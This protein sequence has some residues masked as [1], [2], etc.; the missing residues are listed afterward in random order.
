MK[1]TTK[2]I[3]AL[4]IACLFALAL[5]ACNGNNQGAANKTPEQLL[6]DALQKNREITS[7]KMG[8]GMDV[9]LSILGQ[10]MDMTIDMDVTYTAKKDMYMRMSTNMLGQDQ[11]VE[12]YL[13][14]QDDNSAMAYMGNNGQWVKQLVD[15]SEM[16]GLLSEQATPSE[17]LDNFV[18][19]KD[20]KLAGEE[21]LNGKPAQKLTGK[22]SAAFLKEALASSGLDD[23][24]GDEDFEDL[25]APV[26]LWISDGYIVRFDMDASDMM[27]QIYTALMQGEGFQGEL[28]VGMTYQITFSDFNTAVVEVPA[29][30]QS[31]PDGD[32]GV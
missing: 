21:N 8:L 9:E 2:R 28:E 4:C 13:M 31:A 17:T 25:N 7:G 6:E 29:E 12:M 32:L 26:T 16:E 10:Q 27:N 3:V 5:T 19:I 15:A 11:T 22:V 14:M 23:L 24:F 30:V 18:D 20:L 1:T